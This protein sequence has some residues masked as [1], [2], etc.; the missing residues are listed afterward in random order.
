MWWKITSSSSDSFSGIGG[1]CCS[2]PLLFVRFGLPLSFRARYECFN[3]FINI[4]K[5]ISYE[6]FFAHDFVVRLIFIFFASRI[7]F[8]FEWI[9]LIVCEIIIRCF[10]S[11]FIRFGLLAELLVR[12]FVVV[13]T[14][15]DSGW[16]WSKSI[17]WILQKW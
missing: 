16:L 1:C 14:C 13:P 15:C 17:E 11:H 12:N 7:L 5:F 10:I 9:R 3:Q 6:C 2:I 4:Y 8:E